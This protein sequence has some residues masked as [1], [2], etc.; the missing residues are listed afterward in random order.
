M[1]LGK[2]YSLLYDKVKGKITITYFREIPL[3]NSYCTKFYL[4]YIINLRMFPSESRHLKK[5]LSFQFP[6]ISILNCNPLP[7]REMYYQEQQRILVPG[8]LHVVFH[9]TLLKTKF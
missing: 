7:L 5:F 9:E 4:E 3:S 2:Q 1:L 8:V 6:E